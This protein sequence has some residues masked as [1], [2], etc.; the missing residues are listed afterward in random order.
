[1]VFGPDQFDRER[2]LHIRAGTDHDVDLVGLLGHH[3]GLAVFIGLTT[4][5]GGDFP[6]GVDH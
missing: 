5:E 4:V 3:A 1:M 2:P 6:R